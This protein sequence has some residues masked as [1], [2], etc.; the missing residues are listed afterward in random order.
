[1]ILTTASVMRRGYNDVVAGSRRT[2]SKEAP[3][4]GRTA[5]R[6]WSKRLQAKAKPLKLSDSVTGPAFEP[7]SEG[8]KARIG[9][10]LAHRP[11]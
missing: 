10:D 4:A 11:R 8:Y 6:P 1:M 2:A 7:T 3:Q 9:R 5:S